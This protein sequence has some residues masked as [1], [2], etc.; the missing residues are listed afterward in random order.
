MLVH[1]FVIPFASVDQEAVQV[2][3]LSVHTQVRN[4]SCVCCVA[5]VL[6]RDSE[7]K[8]VAAVQALASPLSGFLGDS[9]DRVYIV[10]AGTVL[11]GAMTAAIGASRTLPEARCNLSP[12]HSAH[13][14]LSACI[15]RLHSASP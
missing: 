7:S 5:E 10:V 9:F 6:A 2:R 8:T 11:W 13:D 4:H 12:A 1:A 15:C 3:A 14:S